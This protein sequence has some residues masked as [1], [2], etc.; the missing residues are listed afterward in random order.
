[1]LS[2]DF[3]WLLDVAT[4]GLV[5]AYAEWQWHSDHTFPNIGL[6][7]VVHILQIFYR[8]SDGNISLI[9]AKVTDHIFTGGSYGNRHKFVKNMALQY[10]LGTVV[11]MPGSFLFFGL[12]VDQNEIGEIKNL[13]RTEVEWAIQ[14]QNSQTPSQGTR[15]PSE[16][17]W[18]ISFSIRK[19]IWISLIFRHVCEPPCLFRRKSFAANRRA[20]YRHQHCQAT[21]NSKKCTTTRFLLRISQTEKGAHTIWVVIFADAGKSSTNAHL[22]ILRELMFG[23]YEVGYI[24]HTLHWNSHFS[25]RRIKQIASGEVLAASEASD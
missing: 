6:S 12:K 16:L 25:L 24:L 7:T 19:W 17:N 5:N 23:P 20:L 15:I 4:Y 11:H 1:M 10:I 2:K 18:E 21:F 3:Y 8:L 9:V 14:P 22:G 13:S